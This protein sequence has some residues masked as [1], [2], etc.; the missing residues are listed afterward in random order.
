ML[1]YIM[2]AATYDGFDRIL[3]FLAFSMV[4]LKAYKWFTTLCIKKRKQ[5]KF[6]KKAIVA[7]LLVLII[8][9]GCSSNSQ[10]SKEASSDTPQTTATKDQEVKCQGSYVFENVVINTYYQEPASLKDKNTVVLEGLAHGEFIEVIVE[11][12]IND[13]KHVELKWD[14][15]KNVLTE[16]G[17]L[18]KFDTITGK[19]VV[20][21][22]YMPDGIPA[23]RIEW[24]TTFG[25]SYE[26]VIQNQTP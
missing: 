11:G 4:T 14:E 3:I 24:K 26:F 8:T 17:V 18:S 12:E 21:K 5:V 7:L 10:P 1:N 13:F 2:E 16:V 6:M 23:E 20:I 22:T 25:K 19:T 9:G 15:Q